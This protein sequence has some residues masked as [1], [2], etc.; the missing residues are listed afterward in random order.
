MRLIF[1]NSCGGGRLR[2]DVWNWSEFFY[3]EYMSLAE[4]AK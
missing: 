2:I 1:Q 4:W 3:V